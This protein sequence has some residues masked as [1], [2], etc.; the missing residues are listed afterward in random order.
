MSSLGHQPFP[1]AAL[2]GAALLLGLSMLGVWAARTSGVGLT[3]MPEAAPVASRELRFED[4]DDGSL[5]VI[6]AQSRGP[7]AVLPPASN[8]FMRGVLRGLARERRRASVGAEPPFRLTRWA[9]GRLSLEDPATGQR[10]NLEVFGPTNAAAF[11]RLLG[12]AGASL[13]MRATAPGATA[14]EGRT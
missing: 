1:R 11:A 8:G 12:D 10:I 2:V 14:Q 13:S 7:V 9:D 6:D 3:R 4:R 5:A